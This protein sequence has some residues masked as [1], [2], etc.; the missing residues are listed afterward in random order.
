MLRLEDTDEL[1]SKEE[2]TK[3]ILDGLH[4]L[5]IT[6]DEGPD[7]GGPFPPY[8]QTEKVDHYEAAA[9]KLI[10]SGH[11]YQCYCTAEELDAL[12][13]EQKAAG[14]AQRYDNRCR[15]NTPEQIDKFQKEGKQPT[16][17]LKID[18]PRV[19]SW[20]DLIKGKIE[21]GTAELGGDMVIVKSSGMALYNFAVVIDDVDMQMTQ[22]I[23]GEDHI[24][25]TAKQLL[26]YEAL[27]AKPPEFAHAPLIFDIERTK[28]SKRK[29]GEMVHVDK[30]KRDGYMP[31]AIVNYLAQMSWQ[32]TDG[33]EIFSL[34]EAAEMFELERLSKS[35][36]VFDIPRLNWFNGQYLRS[37]P[38]NVVTDRAL[39][40]MEAYDT[41]QYSREELEQIVASVREGLTM[42]SEITEAA[43][44]YFEKKVERNS[45]A[46]AALASEAAKKVLKTVLDRV[47]QFPWGD[48]KGCKSIVDGIGKEL[49]LKGKDLYWP[50][51]A[52]LQGKTS[53]P[54]LGVTLAILGKDRVTTRIEGAL[55]L[56][57]R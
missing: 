17:R 45:D 26:I 40:F 31:E 43:K 49:G 7:I 4:W 30:Y 22:V 20:N 51:R 42:L 12:R 38:L 34:A 57:H 25:N 11:A 37:L 2:H 32:P 6:W 21:I 19:V 9:K 56:C 13:D 18:E 46:N 44:F 36:A 15:K 10:A 35:P 53:G 27:G 28:L 48:P 8:R 23:R 24:H 14:Q 5:G 47:D 39:P 3:D 52:A 55:G 50:V 16:V 54:D 41:K 29:H 33:R 1:R